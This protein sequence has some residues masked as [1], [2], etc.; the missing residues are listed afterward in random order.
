MSYQFDIKDEY[1]QHLIIIQIQI[2]HILAES[3]IERLAKLWLD[4]EMDKNFD[5]EDDTDD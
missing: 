2:L 4:D 5:D 3:L 1:M